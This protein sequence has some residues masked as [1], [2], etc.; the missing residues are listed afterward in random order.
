MPGILCSLLTLTQ[1]MM[2]F[3]SVQGAQGGLASTAF[4]GI[5]DLITAAQITGLWAWP[6]AFTDLNIGGLCG[7]QSSP[8]F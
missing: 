1:G 8:C 5:G 4:D 6:V 2:L 7:A 3:P